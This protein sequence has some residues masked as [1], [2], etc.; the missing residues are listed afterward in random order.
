ML[1][2]MTPARAGESKF[3]CGVSKGVPATVARTSRG[4]VPIIRWVSNAFADSG[5]SAEYRCSVVS[6]KFQEY[7]SAGTL[8]YLTTG[9][10]N[11]QPVVCVAATKGGPCSGVLFT[12]RPGSDPWTTLTRLMNVRVQAGPP[13]NES[14]SASS[15]DSQFVDMGDFLATA[16]TEETVFVEPLSTNQGVS[17]P[18]IQINSLW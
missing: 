14:A 3:T 8:N 11:N 16:P 12:L 4:N 15:T 2:L 5:Y 17:T 7:Y 10:A 1:S 18:A 9:T 13:L 6:A